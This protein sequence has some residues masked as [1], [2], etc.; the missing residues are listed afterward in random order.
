MDL[1]NLNPFQWNWNI[2]WVAITYTVAMIIFNVIGDDTVGRK[3]AS[4]ILIGVAMYLIYH[5]DR[6]RAA[7]RRLPTRDD[8]ERM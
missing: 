8:H 1:R 5:F 2:K 4:F 3:I 6:R 7:M